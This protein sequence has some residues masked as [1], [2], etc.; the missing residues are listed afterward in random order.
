MKTFEELN[1][2]EKAVFLIWGKQ[3]DFTTTAHFPI[4]KINK[5]IKRVL[6]KLKDKDIRRINRT[7]ITSGF[8]L[9]HPTR[10]NTTYNLSHEGLRHCEFLRDDRD[11]SHLI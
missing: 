1:P 5:K 4:Q 10:R 3:L 2:M 9:E 6:P 7:L 8:I 11:Y